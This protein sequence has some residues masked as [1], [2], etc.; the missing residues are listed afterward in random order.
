MARHG[1]RP[2]TSFYGRRLTYREIGELVDRTAAALQ[3]LGVVKGTKVGLFMPNCPTFIVYYFAILKA[4]VRSST[5]TRS[6]RST[7]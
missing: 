2:C 7:S 1:E 6:T 4:G 5:T 3:T